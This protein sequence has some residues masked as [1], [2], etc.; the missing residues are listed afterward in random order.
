MNLINNVRIVPIR[1]PPSMESS[2]IIA[3]EASNFQNRKVTVT[4]IAFC[5]ENIPAI[6][7]KKMRRITV[8]IRYYFLFVVPFELVFAAAFF[9]PSS[10]AI[11]ASSFLILDTTA[12]T[13]LS[14]I[15][16]FIF[17]LRS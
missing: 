6:I 9:L 10:F 17:E 8:I 12:F 16:F 2:T 1:I 11:W 15:G 7:N 5:K 4:G 14:S 13:S 3:S